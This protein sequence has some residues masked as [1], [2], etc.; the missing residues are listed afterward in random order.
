MILS[1]GVIPIGFN[2]V[3]NRVYNFDYTNAQGVRTNPDHLYSFDPPD[4]KIRIQ[5]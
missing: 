4:G 1:L 2:I 5:T 3:P